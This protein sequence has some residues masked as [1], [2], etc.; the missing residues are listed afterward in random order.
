MGKTCIFVKKLSLLHIRNSLYYT[1]EN[2]NNTLE[3]TVICSGCFV[4]LD[5]PHL[6]WIS[7]FHL[8]TLFHKQWIKMILS[9][10][11]S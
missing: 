6:F 5:A 1:L 3:N 4:F 7:S 8:F 2:T 10:R 11:C 9:R